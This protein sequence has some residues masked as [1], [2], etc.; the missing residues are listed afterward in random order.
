MPRNHAQRTT[1]RQALADPFTLRGAQ[2]AARTS[3]RRRT[4]TALG[5]D[6]GSDADL[7]RRQQASN[8][9]HRQTLMPA[10]PQLTLQVLSHVMCH[11]NLPPTPGAIPSLQPRVAL[12][13]RIYH[14]SIILDINTAPRSLPWTADQ[15]RSARLCRWRNWKR[16]SP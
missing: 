4:D 2:C 5:A 11:W 7:V 15:P 9:R 13:T 14:L 3:P 1:G 12:M 6:Q 10:F 8:L 16:K